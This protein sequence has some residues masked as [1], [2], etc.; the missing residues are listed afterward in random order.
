[1]VSD[2]T[3][4]LCMIVKN[5]QDVLARCLGSAKNLVDEIIIVDT[6]SSDK[7]KEIAYLYTDK[8]YDFKWV[9]DFSKARNFSFSKATKDYIMWLDAD[10]VIT[11]SEQKKFIELKNSLTNDVDMIML[12]YNVGFD[13]ND[14]VTLSYYRERI[15]KN[16]KK[17]VWEGQ[18]HEVI[19]PHGKILHK[20]IYIE[21][22]KLHQSDPKR[23][24]NIFL[25]MKL[26]GIKFTPREQFY[27]ARE[28]YYN[29]LYNE[30]IME[31][32]N[33]LDNKDGWIENKINAC[34]DLAECYTLIGKKEKSFLTLLRSFEFD[35]PR[36][37]ICSLVGNY[38]FNNE[39]YKS[40]I[41][42]Y[43]LATQIK[44]D[45][46]K[47][48]FCLIDY[49]KFIPYMQLSLCY[50]RLGDINNAIEFNE[51]AGKV[52]P[53]NSSYLY[54]KDFFNTLTKNN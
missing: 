49:Y 19:A 38:F 10:D 4:S 8:V 32:N 36:A 43:N 30:A 11:K 33:F 40:A 53:T 48:G 45:I 34:I 37:E 46:T 31:F 25:D 23:N 51:K 14:N 9:N 50:Y 21:H 13:E 18:I 6:G 24:I 26:N 28:L 3:I 29:K 5:E 1:M 16:D 41:Y 2:I 12:K 20:D 54:N 7:T 35:T 44:P 52:K 17:A 22:R 15:I 42:W 27:F 39:N 47:G